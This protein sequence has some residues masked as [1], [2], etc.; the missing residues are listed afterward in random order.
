MKILPFLIL[1]A[2]LTAEAQTAYVPDSYGYINDSSFAQMIR[3]RKYDYIYPFLSC[4]GCNSTAE[5]AMIS[6]KGKPGVIDLYGREVLPPKFRKIDGN[7][8]FNTRVESIAVN[9]GYGNE[10]QPFQNKGIK[11]IL[12]YGNRGFITEGKK[13][14]L[15]D[16]SGRRRQALNYEAIQ[17]LNGQTQYLSTRIGRSYGVIHASGKEIFPAI[18]RSVDITGHSGDFIIR[19]NNK[20]CLLDKDGNRLIDTVYEMIRP[21]SS[22]GKNLPGDAAIPDVAVLQKG[23]WGVAGRDGSVKIPFTHN[24]ISY[25][26]NGYYYVMNGVS[27]GIIDMGGSVIVPLSYDSIRYFR[28]QNVFVAGNYRRIAGKGKTFYFGLLDSAGKQIVPMK[29]HAI[30]FEE[31]A[32]KLGITRLDKRY[33]I[34]HSGGL[35]I[36][37]LAYAQP[38]PEKYGRQFCYRLKYDSLGRSDSIRVYGNLLVTPDRCIYEKDYR[39]GMASHSGNSLFPPVYDSIGLIPEGGYMMKLRGCYGVTDSSG[40]EL[41]PAVYDRI[42]EDVTRKGFSYIVK[43]KKMGYLW[44]YRKPVFRTKY[45]QLLV[46]D[47]R[48]SARTLAISRKGK[49]YGIIDSSD[50]V[51]IPFHYWNLMR[52]GFMLTRIP[53]E[54][55]LFNG[56]PYKYIHLKWFRNGF[57]VVY[58]DSGVNVINSSFTE[59]CPL[60]FEDIYHHHMGYFRTLRDG[61]Y[62]IMDT[63]MKELFA[64]VY[65]HLEGINGYGCIIFKINGKKGVMDL[66]GNIILQP[67][68]DNICAEKE[69]GG[70]IARMEG[71]SY[72]IDRYGHSIPYEGFAGCSD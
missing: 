22:Q 48:H 28:R 17:V 23:R 42:Y 68:Y 16:S 69:K 53:V 46:I 44:Q 1:M 62:G 4:E 47:Q 52:K 59:I 10:V 30:E 39:W 27:K 67:V 41:L 45:E 12:L 38:V 7:P 25:V 3:E 18:Y 14:L 66:L 5:F 43:G 50:N 8:I 15:H 24:R 2:A 26:G 56:T 51:V 21:F 64:P 13:L 54:E 72:R 36:A 71:K 49:T 9:K 61:H 65:E 6:R 34:I 20:Y 70:W 31:A 63:T 60:Q 32:G 40:A 19:I 57:A 35:E 37:A 11:V 33:G 29:Y 58:T 55:E